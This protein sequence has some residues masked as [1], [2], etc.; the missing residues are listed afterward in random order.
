ME[1]LA[2][3]EVESF[4]YLARFEGVDIKQGLASLEALLASL[5]SPQFA[6][7]S[8]IVGGTNGKGSVVAMLSAI[9]SRAGLFVGSYTSPHLWRFNER[10][11]LEAECISDAEIASLIKTIKAHPH[12]DVTWFELVTAM[13]FLHFR[14]HAVD[15][16]VLEVGM[17]GRLDATNTAKT[18][19]S[20]IT[21]I[22]LDHQ[23][24]LGNTVAEIAQEKAGI[25]K[26]GGVCITGERKE[27]S[28][29][30][31]ADKAKSA[32]LLR[33]D[34]DFSFA[35]SASGLIYRSKH[36]PPI[37][38]IQL[39]LRGPHQ[40][41]NAL[42]AITAALLVGKRYGYDISADSIR[43]GLRDCHWPG[44]FEIIAQKP[45]VIFDGAHN[46]AGMSAL[47]AALQ[48]EFPERKIVAI[49]GFLRGKDYREMLRVLSTIATRIIVVAPF[50][51]RALPAQEVMEN[52][53]REIEILE[54]AAS[55]LD[56]YERA[57]ALALRNEGIICFAG[58]LFLAEAIKDLFP[59][60]VSR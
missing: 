23:E 38:G 12:Q 50:S 27:E 41:D 57:R 54:S 4:A 39:A 16:A 19:I 56:A 48:E 17:G 5:S 31:I 34:E 1:R 51:P 8:I 33:I 2:N 15:L 7:P 49:V 40:R 43:G 14:L 6:Y 30:V 29:A 35:E 26:D 52:C 36:F 37:T 25:I 10:I 55:A 28:L 24:Y 21:N 3:A 53:G 9:F 45:T 32:L 58:S 13:A 44:R 18:V 20:V 47:V 42:C 60:R 59:Q 22:A 11:R 46:V